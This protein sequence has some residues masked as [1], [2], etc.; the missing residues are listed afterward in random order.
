MTTNFFYDLVSFFLND[1]QFAR[2]SVI[3]GNVLRR[4]R[5]LRGRTSLFRRFNRER[6]PGVYA[7]SYRFT[8][9]RVPRPHRGIHGHKFTATEQSRGYNRNVLLRERTSIIRS[10]LILVNRTRVTGLCF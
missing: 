2:T 10:F 3:V 9:F 5:P 4:M 6:V 8:K 1:I 7:A